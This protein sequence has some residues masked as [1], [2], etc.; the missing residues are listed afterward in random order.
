MAMSSV[1]KTTILLIIAVGVL[2]PLLS[3]LTPRVRLPVIVLEI[4]LGIIVGPQ[5]LGWGEVGPVIHSLSRF[6][7]AFLFFLA[8]FEV[9]FNSIR[10]R[11]LQR[12]FLG[13]LLSFSIAFLLGPALR[14]TGFVRSDLVISVA[15]TTTALGVLIPILKDEGE[16]D[17]RF[18]AFAI[19]TATMGEFGPIVMISLLLTKEEGGGFE[20]LSFMALFILIVIIAAFLAARLRPPALIELLR[21][22]MHSSSALPLRISILIL[23]ILVTL[24]HQFG[25]ESILGAVAAGVVVSLAAEG[26]GR[27]ILQQKFE[28]IGYGFLIPIFFI[29]SGM[30]YDLNALISSTQSMLRL[31]LYLLLFLV[32]R[33]FSV[34][35]YRK[36]LPSKDLVPM[37]FFSATALPLVVAITEIGVQT[38]QMRSANAAALV[39]AG[40][41]SVFLFPAVALWLRHRSPGF[42]VKKEPQ[43]DSL[44]PS[45]ILSQDRH[46]ESE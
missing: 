19:A 16:K 3:Q 42:A 11:P 4:A 40:M 30:T 43:A 27:R 32:A 1:E 46:I 13:W 36:D 5:V 37:A 23:A 9:D 33:G 17:S 12:A 31:P 34:L 24:T 20:A 35:L 8:G 21:K 39:G 10:G 38:H 18:G 15:L 2:A 41:I 29:A 26:E 7:L 28:A 44:T 6:G 45:A 25:L 14:F 22:K